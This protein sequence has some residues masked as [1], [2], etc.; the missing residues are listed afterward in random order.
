MLVF[1]IGI[2]GENQTGKDKLKKGEI[3]FT[4]GQIMSKI[5]SWTEKK[6]SVESLAKRAKKDRAFLKKLLESNESDITK[7]KYKSA[8]VLRFISEENPEVLYPFWDHFE[9]RLS[10]DNTFLRSDAMFVIG[11]LTA[12]DKK[13]RFEK[14]FNL[15]YK[16]LDDESMIPSANLAGISGKIAI[17][18]PNLQ[19]KI[20]NRLMKIDSTDHSDECKNIIKGKAIDSFSQFYDMTSSANQKKILSFVKNELKNKRPGTRKKAE[21]FLKKW[22]KP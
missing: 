6:V 21:R 14:V 20:I 18:N 1:P 8:K 12:V 17:A 9:K 13:G 4:F 7:V 16:Q 2:F 15:C 10:S 3:P 19:T 5:P 22:S 11:N